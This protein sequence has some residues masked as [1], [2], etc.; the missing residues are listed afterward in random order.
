MTFSLA[1]I[2]RRLVFAP[3]GVC[4]VCT[5]LTLTTTAR[6]GLALSSPGPRRNFDGRAPSRKV[7][8]LS[9]SRYDNIGDD[10]YGGANDRGQR[11]GRSSRESAN[12][13][14]EF[15]GRGE[16]RQRR[17]DSSSR[18]R[19]DFDDNEYDNYGSG[20]NGRNRDDNNDNSYNEKGRNRYSSDGRK[21]QLPPGGRGGRGR[22]RGRGNSREQQEQP[23]RP[24]PPTPPLDSRPTYFTCRHTYET[25]LRLELQRSLA[26]A[27]PP[28]DE[29]RVSF[30]R[31]HPGLVLA[32]TDDEAAAS[33]LSGLRPAYALQAMPDCVVVEAESIKGLAREVVDKLL[34]TP[35]ETGEASGLLRSEL[36]TAPK[37]SL[38]VHSLVPEMGR[39]M[40]ESQL[41]QYRRITKIGEEIAG[42][43]K[44]RCRAARATNDDDDD[45]DAIQKEQ[46]LLQIM[47]LEPQIVVASFA[48]CVQHDCKEEEVAPAPT[49]TTP[50]PNWR[51]PNWNL[52]AG[53]ALVDI[54]DEQRNSPIR[55]PSSAYRKLLEAFWYMG[56]RPPQ[57][58]EFQ[59]VDLGACPGGWTG[60]L[61]LMGCRV[62]AVDRS[63]LD[64][65][66]M[67]DTAGVEYFQGDAFRFV[68]PWARDGDGDASS[69]PG[70]KLEQPHPNTWM[71]SDIIAYP[72]KITELLDDWCGKNWVSHAIVT[73]KFQSEIPW[74][75]VDRATGIVEGHGY[76]CRTVHFF[77]N[78]NEV[79]FLAVKDGYSNNKSI[80]TLLGQPMYAPIL[81]K[82]K[83]K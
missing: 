34:S 25:C 22:G 67:K 68:P 43:L 39:G 47:L 82:P 62:I 45:D 57:G 55:I 75:D 15:Y 24:R 65:T 51:W 14:A 13:D 48:R 83:K 50:L 78:K 9:S 72:D 63:P 60:A 40:P 35:T 20:N 71:I 1:P 81:P 49:T 77:N 26:A 31:P 11:R 5:F 74:E 18:S 2:R 23:E 7:I 33:F 12:N 73:I 38:A 42:Q 66:L 53:L 10:S 4:A 36:V 46:W 6:Y 17:S 56:E 59:V 32:T 58:S 30:Q 79:T 54:E 29:N 61:R 70:L 64:S 80:N 52:P 76:S 21:K 19:R 28:I 37:G 16:G 69:W 8:E 41:P 27:D 3:I 44:K